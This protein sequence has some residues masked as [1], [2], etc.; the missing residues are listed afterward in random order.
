MSAILSPERPA[1]RHRPT[2]PDHSVKQVRDTLPHDARERSAAAGVACFVVSALGWM[3]TAAWMALAPTWWMRVLLAVANG[4]AAGVLFVVGHDACHG[5]LTPN[6]RLNAWLGRAAFLPSLHPFVAW[7]HSHNALHHG[8]TNLR[9]K[10]PVY[11]PLTLEEYRALGPWRRTLERAYRSWYGVGLLYVLEI[12]WPLEMRPSAEHRAHIDRRGSFAADRAL[13]LAFVALH[14]AAL[15]A[16]ARWGGA[17]LGAACGIAVLGL[18]V[19]FAAFAWLMGFA[20]FQHHTHPRVLWYDDE[21][22][23]SYFRSQVQGTVHVEFPAW[24]DALLHH[25]MDHTAHHVDT[26]VPLYRLK[27]AQRAVEAAFG[28]ANVITERFTL[29]GTRRTFRTC[30]LYD[31]RAHRWLTFDGVPT[32]AERRLDEE[33]RASA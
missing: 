4:L 15:A 12:W 8:W 18:V 3:A 5:S 9:G 13:V 11:A 19:P 6:A 26:R 27:D 30:Q 31:Y 22:E 25:I 24:A 1:A 10:D 2:R 14:A 28:E 29:A 17:P 21:R 7:A 32:T 16:L 23:W 20:T 33:A